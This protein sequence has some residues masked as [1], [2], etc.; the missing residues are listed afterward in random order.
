MSFRAEVFREIWK[1]QSG[2]R[3]TASGIAHGSEQELDMQSRRGMFRHLQVGLG[4]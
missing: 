4:R 3:D 2:R 1:G